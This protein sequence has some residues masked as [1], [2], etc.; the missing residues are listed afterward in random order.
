MRARSFSEGTKR[1]VS[2]D[3]IAVAADLGRTGTRSN[4]A[5]L[6]RSVY[7][8]SP[9]APNQYPTVLTIMHIGS[10]AS[11]NLSFLRARHFRAARVL[12][13]WTQEELA[14]RARVVRRT[15]VMIEAGA[16]RTQARKVQAVLAALGAG[17]I[18][19][20]CS[21]DG[22]VSLIDGNARGSS[23][24]DPGHVGEERIELLRT[25]VSGRHPKASGAA[26][27]VAAGPS[28]TAPDC[29]STGFSG[30]VRRR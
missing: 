10:N 20:V 4:P 16:K 30:H 29:R 5:G 27:V 7:G 19:F 22:E 9:N 14:R 17:G 12:L 11:E 25:R 1:P 24:I 8:A 26:R 6:I 21:G 13:D 3:G 23:P 18:R 28:P 15:V 2:L